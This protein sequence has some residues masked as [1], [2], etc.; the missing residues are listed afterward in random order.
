MKEL[1]TTDTVVVIAEYGHG[2]RA[3]TLSDYTL[4]VKDYTTNFIDNKL[5]S[6][7]GN[8][9]F[10]DLKII[11]KAYSGLSNKEIDYMTEK[12]RSIMIRDEGSRIIVKPE[13]VLEVSFDIVQKSG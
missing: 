3:G 4:A 7:N 2:K 10:G 8:N 11:G 6:E 12:L 9:V 5:A 1:D 13:I